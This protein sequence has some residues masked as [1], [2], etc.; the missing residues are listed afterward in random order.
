M[1]CWSGASLL[2]ERNSPDEKSQILKKL[3]FWASCR[4]SVMDI[5]VF[6]YILAR[7]LR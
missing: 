5:V 2:M 4:D 6:G 7:S 1:I 3:C